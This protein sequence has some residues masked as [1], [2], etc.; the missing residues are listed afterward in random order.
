VTAKRMPLAW[1]VR[2]YI[3]NKLYPFQT[4][5]HKQGRW[6]SED[7]KKLLGEAPFL[8]D[9]SEP[10][11]VDLPQALAQAQSLAR[12]NSG[13]KAS[14]FLWN[15]TT[16]GIL[17]S[18]LAA[19]PGKRV[20][21]SR[22]AHRSAFAALALAGAEPCYCIPQTLPSWE[23][24]LPIEPGEFASR[25]PEADAIFLTHP[26]YWGLCRNWQDLIGY[27]HN[28]DKVVVVDQAH[29]PHFRLSPK[30]PPDAIAMG[31][32]LVVESTHKLGTALTQSSMLHL[33]TERVAPSLVEEALA[34]VQS[35]S[36]S[37]LLLLS[38]EAQTA[39]EAAYGPLWERTVALATSCRDKLQGRG[40]PVLSEA[41]LPDGLK[42][43][44]T[45]LVVHVR[46]KGQSG[47]TASKFLKE[48]AGVVPEMADQHNLV[49]LLTPA[50][51]EESIER[52][53]AGFE[54]LEREGEAEG[55]I[56]QP[57]FPHSALPPRQALT[58]KRGL[59][60]LNDAA[61][62]IAGS[63][64]VPYPPGIPLLA[65][66]DVIGKE[67]VEYLAWLR[68]LGWQVDGITGQ[69]EILIYQGG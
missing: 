27:A 69:G 21:L 36:P 67:Q 15:G 38:L 28:Q 3:E 20:L 46:A 35:T 53:V 33:G 31:A 12:E 61:G 59:R 17:A 56:P 37:F 22:C 43:D 47:I 44:P 51:D 2:R 32:D 41:D 6:V 63:M 64:V 25:L 30:L 50:D 11:G 54:L 18:F 39:E 1:G 60:A 52:L 9:L 13:A 57:P 68:K 4:P 24:F 34:M 58:G 5:G 14:F 23:I 45:R 16:G 65:P 8:V 10:Q 29:G 48:R 19:C 26:S 55:A 49:F 40:W 62:E 66:G 42:L 7:L